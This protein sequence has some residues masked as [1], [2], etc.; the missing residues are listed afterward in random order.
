M[1]HSSICEG[2]QCSLKI[3]FSGKVWIC[4]EF[5][6]CVALLSINATISYSKQQNK[7]Y[8][9]HFSHLIGHI[10]ILKVLQCWDSNVVACLLT[11]KVPLSPWETNESMCSFLWSQFLA[12]FLKT[13]AKDRKTY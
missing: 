12:Q 1:T 2:K 9:G 5:L 13:F 4:Y 7:T 8:N 3:Y 11:P 6:K 10:F